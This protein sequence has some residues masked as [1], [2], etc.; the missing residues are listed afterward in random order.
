MA[1]IT[2]FWL[3]ISDENGSSCMEV[4]STD[5]KNVVGKIKVEHIAFYEKGL[6]NISR[7]LPSTIKNQ[8]TNVAVKA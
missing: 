8:D 6:D 5:I 2:S 3:T 4:F 1:N 7:L